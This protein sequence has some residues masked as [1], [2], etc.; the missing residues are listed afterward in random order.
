MNN[1]N[2]IESLKRRTVKKILLYA[3]YPIDLTNNYLGCLRWTKILWKYSKRFSKLE[4]S[5]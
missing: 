3:T 1:A 2:D 4:P 5:T